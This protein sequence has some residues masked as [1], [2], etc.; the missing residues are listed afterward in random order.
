M[1]HEIFISYSHKDKTTA[2]AICNHLESR[3]MRCWYAPRDITP[4]VEWGNAILKGIED[5]KIM[6][7][8]FTKDANLSQQVLREVNNAVNSGLSIIPFRLTEEEPAAGM[9]YYLST[10][11]WMDAMNEELESAISSLGDL[12]QAIIEK[13]PVPASAAEKHETAAVP[14]KKR[15]KGI[16]IA[17]ASLVLVLAAALVL[18]FTSGKRDGS[19]SGGTGTDS[20]SAEESVYEFEG[21][22]TGKAEIGHDT[23]SDEVLD[24]GATADNAVDDLSETYIDGNDQSNILNGGHLAYDGEWYYYT[25]N[26][27][28]RMYRMREDGSD[29][30]ALTDVPAQYISVYDGW[31]YFVSDEELFRMKPD[32]SELT[33]LVSYGAKYA[34]IQ[35]GRIYYGEFGLNSA[36]LDGSGEREENGIDGYD[37]VIDGTYTYYIDPAHDN[38]LYRANMDGS[39]AKCILNES[40][41][42]LRMAGKL[43]FYNTN[44]DPSLFTYDVTTGET[45]QL[46]TDPVNEAVI[47]EDA[48]YGTSGSLRIISIPMKGLGIKTLTEG[49]AD[50]VNVCGNKIFYRDCDDYQ[51]YM[52]DLDGSNKTKL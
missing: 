25:S 21:D 26:D 40:L 37:V 17:A 36:A 24:L 33:S 2:D 51:Y 43:L 47:T 46:T 12:C 42:S 29:A 34:R 22:D 13:K 3:E 1:A 8:V 6:V 27:G 45:T 10:V 4:G 38:H 9:K 20:G 44:D 32:G 15:G 50:T 30:A 11:H 23:S 18:I 39:D 16:W 31:V 52:M 28:G 35:N 7:L 41:V 5:A 48:V 14:G 19:D 49:M